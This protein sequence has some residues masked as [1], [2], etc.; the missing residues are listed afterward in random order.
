MWKGY[1]LPCKWE[2]SRQ[3]W[4]QQW[5]V[6]WASYHY[7]A[8]TWSMHVQSINEVMCPDPTLSLGKG[9]CSLLPRPPTCTLSCWVAHTGQRLRLLTEEVGHTWPLLVQITFLSVKPRWDMEETV[10]LQG[11]GWCLLNILLLCS[12]VL[13]S[14]MQRVAR[15]LF[16]QLVPQTA[17]MQLYS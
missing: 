9:S 7:F 17:L 6:T 11:F 8:L 2:V 4:Q 14:S 3:S 13:E 16:W 12:V 10:R 5:K 15:S 1:D